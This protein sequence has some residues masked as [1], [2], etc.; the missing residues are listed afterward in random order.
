MVPMT[1]YQHVRLTNKTHFDINEETLQR[2]VWIVYR[3]V[4]IQLLHE[5]QF[6]GKN[7]ISGHFGVILYVANEVC[8]RDIEL[9][10]L[11]SQIYTRVAEIQVRYNKG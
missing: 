2:P 4:I 5:Q 9:L 7:Q 8:D 3:Q 1:I 11:T 10:D 6:L